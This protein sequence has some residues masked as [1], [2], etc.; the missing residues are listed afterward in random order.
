MDIRRK[1]IGQGLVEYAFILVLVALVIIIIL[2]LLGTS[3][4]AVFSKITSV[5]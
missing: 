5:I 4:G 3:I 1:L 2:A